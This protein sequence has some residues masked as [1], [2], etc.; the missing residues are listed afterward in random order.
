MIWNWCFY[1]HLNAGRTCSLY[2]TSHL[3][4]QSCNLFL[5]IILQIIGLIY[6]ILMSFFSCALMTLISRFPLN[7]KPFVLSF[8]GWSYN[9]LLGVVK[10]DL[11]LMNDFF[12]KWMEVTTPVIWI[13]KHSE[14]KWTFKW[15]PSRTY[16]ISMMTKFA[17]LGFYPFV[18]FKKLF[19]L[20]FFS[21]IQSSGQEMFWV[22]CP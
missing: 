12:F 20:V 3:F 8:K 22:H 13:S 18:S 2:I 19:F 16:Q 4:S 9:T 21:I 1:R 5:N 10:Q 11:F 15:N 6:F 14:L 17:W 7:P